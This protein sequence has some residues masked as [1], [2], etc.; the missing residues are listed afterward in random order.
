MATGTYDLTDLLG[1]EDQPAEVFGYDRL[2][3]IIQRDISATNTVVNEVMSLFAVETTER[4]EGAPTGGTSRM[5]RIDPDYG[6]SRTQKPSEGAAK[7]G[8]PLDAHEVAA[9]WTAMYLRE[10]TP[11]DLAR[12][13]LSARGAYIGALRDGLM[14]AFFTPTNYT[15]YDYVTPDK[16]PVD[17]KALANG[18]GEVPPTTATGKRFS[19]AHNHYLAN[20]GL[21]IAALLE[22]GRTVTEHY[23][24][25]R[26]VVYISAD[27]EATI[28][29]LA[30]GG[31]APYLPSNIIT[32]QTAPIGVG[33]LDLT[34]TDDRPIG[35][36]P[37]GAVVHTKPW[38]P[39]NYALSINMN[40]PRPL[41]RR[42][43]R[44]AGLRGLFL[45]AENVAA[46][47][48][49]QAF[50]AYF[51]FGA[52][53]RYAASVLYFGGDT[54]EAPEYTDYADEEGSDA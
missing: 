22:A 49:A 21:T 25:N 9:G 47:L 23:D 1:I 29:G 19:G 18:D 28:K 32:P 6:R 20:D 14:R 8:F 39:H 43:H 44:N 4:E 45:A 15:F 34:Q 41:K 31:F 13:T 52:S 10:A 5:V 51:G 2:N 27:D 48:Q 54:Y 7:R 53:D 3:E 46:P 50:Q 12:T 38:V 30:A 16:M 42:V 11:S 36:L 35:V 26:L 24:N 33:S 17:V 37:N 40:A